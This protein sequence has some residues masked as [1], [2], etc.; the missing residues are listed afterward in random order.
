[1][2][3]VGIIVE[4]NPLHNGHVYH[5]RR[6][7]ET[8]GAEACV[9]VMSGHF[10]QRGEPAI[11]NKWARAEMA[12]RMGADLVIE[13]PV[14]YSSQP[15]E[16]FAYGAVALLESTG[17]VDSLVFG[18]EDGRIEPLLAMAEM[19]SEESD[20]F[21]IALKEELKKGGSYPSAYAAAAS[22]L[23]EQGGP[24]D[25][26]LRLDLPN[27]SL[28]LH[29][30]IALHRLGSSIQPMTVTRTKAGYHQE[31]IS[32]ERI[33]SATAIRKL[34]F[35]SEGSGV[36]WEDIAP[37]IPEYT[38]D[39]LRRESAAGRGPLEWSRYS[40][41]LLARLLSSS[42]EE[43]SLHHE[44]TEGLE[45]RIL[46][47]LQRFTGEGDAAGWSVEALLAELKTKRYTHTKLQRTLLRILLS[48]RKH[49]LTRE[50]LS[51]GP[52]YLR[53]LGFSSKGRELLRLMK[54]KAKLP[55]LTKVGGERFADLDMDIRATGIYA[56]GYQQ[57]GSRDW[58][59][60]YF[61]APIQ[62]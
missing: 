41:P 48:H 33:A 15:A 47:A 28:G 21:Q 8:S 24:S 11:V 9:A 42:P 18:S 56:L 58:F 51:A 2:R 36:S 12:L 19:L 16:W 30:L 6:A 1:M 60:D 45:H 13:L 61:E 50:K 53:I 31:D 26:R 39:I 54:H 22:Q 46:Q 32:D 29:Y 10:L 40:Q 7:K 52:E 4:Y 37:Y 3:T 34:V 49:E 20:A 44:V 55:V 23:A 59:R 38:L 57:A 27:N 25:E 35:G 43:L 17:V 14:A 62:I 5:F